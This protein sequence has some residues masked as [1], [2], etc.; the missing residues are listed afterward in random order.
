MRE[1]VRALRASLG[2]ITVG[3]PEE[4]Q[5]SLG[6]IEGKL[7]DVLGRIATNSAGIGKL[8]ERV[9]RL[10]RWRYTLVGVALAAGAVAKFVFHI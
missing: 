3:N 10:E 6:R 4:V 8:D 9:T 5:R 2:A 7:D 1:T